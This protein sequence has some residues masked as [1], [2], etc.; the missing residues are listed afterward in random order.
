MQMCKPSEKV[1]W[2]QHDIGK[3]D[4]CS[5]AYMLTCE[6]RQREDMGFVNTSIVVTLVDHK[7]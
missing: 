6:A 5:L 7:P 1:H 3:C 2:G 4:L